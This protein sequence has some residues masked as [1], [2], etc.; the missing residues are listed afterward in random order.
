MISKTLT[1]FADTLR[2]RRRYRRDGAEYV[3]VVMMAGRADAIIKALDELA[4]CHKI[5]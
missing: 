2:E 3:T 1:D 4:S 5:P